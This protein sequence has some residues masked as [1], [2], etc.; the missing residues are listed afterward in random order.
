MGI[1]EFHLKPP[2]VGPNQSQATHYQ[3]YTA[4]KSVLICSKWWVGYCLKYFI[5]YLVHVSQV[6]S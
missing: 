5:P 2:S 1:A 4:I 3:L 6:S